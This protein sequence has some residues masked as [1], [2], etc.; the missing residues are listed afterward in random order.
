MN[1]E[2][3]TLYAFTYFG[4]LQTIWTNDSAVP[5]IL[6]DSNGNIYRGTD[7][8]LIDNVIYYKGNEATYDEN[9]NVTMPSIPVTS[10]IIDASG[11]RINNIDSNHQDF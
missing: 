11:N 8:S 7:W 10:Y 4:T 1:I 3:K 2:P 9:A 5:S 6:C